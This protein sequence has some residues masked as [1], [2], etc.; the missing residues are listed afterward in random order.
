MSH[1]PSLRRGP[2]KGSRFPQDCGGLTGPG[3]SPGSAARPSA[4]ASFL[5]EFIDYL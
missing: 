3:I 2:E 1:L 4:W 5:N